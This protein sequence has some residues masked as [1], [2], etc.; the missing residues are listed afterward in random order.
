MEF[1]YLFILFLEGPNFVYFFPSIVPNTG[2]DTRVYFFMEG[3][4]HA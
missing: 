3:H 4:M 1:L 2:T